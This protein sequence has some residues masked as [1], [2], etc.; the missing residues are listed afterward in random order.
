MLVA[1]GLVAASLV[2][3]TTDVAQAATCQ[4]SIR[5]NDLGDTGGGRQLRGALARVCDQG[6]ITVKRGTITLVDPAALII[7][8]GRRVTVQPTPTRGN[9]AVPL[10][11][12][13]TGPNG[14]FRVLPGSGLTLND[15]TLDG[16][17]A[18]QGATGGVYNAGTLT[19]HDSTI[20]DFT[21]DSGGGIYNEGSGASVTLDGSAAI[22][23]NS[24]FVLA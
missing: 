1:G 21:S 4:A 6:T 18:P 15:L 20:T 8:G 11:I 10:K 19:L 16:T 24:G 3:V 7:D 14:V 13:A 12:V 17:G 23:R 2:V 9:K 5:V 22:R